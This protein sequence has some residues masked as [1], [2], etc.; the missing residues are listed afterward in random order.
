[1]KRDC[2]IQTLPWSIEYEYLWSVDVMSALLWK[3]YIN[4]YGCP[5]T[6]NLHQD[7][8]DKE[9]QT[10]LSTLDSQ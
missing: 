10:T 6:Q 9:S 5:K 4:D 8:D 1:M 3:E 7:S 2:A